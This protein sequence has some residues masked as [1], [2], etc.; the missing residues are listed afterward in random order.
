M[1]RVMDVYMRKLLICLFLLTFA[2]PIALAL[3]AF[4][5]EPALPAAAALTATEAAQSHGL[6]KRI[7]NTVN[8][9]EG[10]ATLSATKSEIDG[11]IAAAARIVKPL[12]GRTTI[13][14]DGVDIA[15][16]MQI[17]GAQWLGWLN[18][19]A[20][21]APSETGLDVRAVR[22]GGI[23][24][25]PRMTV[26]AA[27]IVLDALTA[28]NI[29]TM[30]LTS[31]RKLETGEERITVTV[32]T[33]GLGDASLFSRAVDGAR[34]AAGFGGGGGGAKRHFAA[35]A[36]AAAG[37]DLPREGSVAPWLRL[38]LLRVAEADHET[39]A[40]ARADLKAALLALAAH[41]GS[42][43][44]LETIFGNISGGETAPSACQGLTLRGR[45]DLRQHFTVSAALAAAGGGAASF[46]MGEVKELVDAG[47]SG[48]SGFSFDDIAID[49]AGI[50]FAEAAAAVA[51]A[52][53]AAMAEAMSVEDSFAPS[54]EGLASLMPQ[55]E[56]ERRYGD[57]DSDAYHDQIAQIDARI[58][59]LPLYAR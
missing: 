1:N 46:G 52:G 56:F 25:P 59:A 34:E 36:E 26:A 15:L 4:Q 47:D 11:L 53:L 9:T 35:L 43:K 55:A 44:A 39:A 5:S 27:R 32:D 28:E 57:V 10:D 24:L 54:V 22:I 18:V 13:G 3:I 50:R 37:G 31:V 40:A 6:V 19:G 38:A 49:R 51:P 16:S 17:P 29:G 48:G 30:L 45:R 21:A 2:A 7:R 42:K 23:D 14:G 58:G 20:R 12:R 33:G 41:C 8:K